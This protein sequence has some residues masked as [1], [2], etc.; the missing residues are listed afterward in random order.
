MK[1]APTIYIIYTTRFIITSCCVFIL[2]GEETKNRTKECVCLLIQYFM[3]S[4][5]IRTMNIQIAWKRKWECCINSQRR[6]SRDKLGSVMEERG[7]VAN[8]YMN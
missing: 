4:E 2:N 7:L 6:K 8:T 3:R 1:H 5:K